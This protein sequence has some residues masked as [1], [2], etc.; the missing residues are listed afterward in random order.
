MSQDNLPPAFEVRLKEIL[1]QQP[2][3]IFKPRLCQ[4]F[5]INT[6]KISIEEAHALLSNRNIDFQ[7]VDFCP[8]VVIVEKSAAQE[9][10][11][12]DIAS[13]GLLYAQGLESVLPVIILDPRPHQRVLDLCAAP[14]S[15]TSQMAMHMEN[16]GV[17]KANEPIRQRR[18]PVGLKAVLQ[19]MGAQARIS[20][21][22]R[23]ASSSN[24]ECPA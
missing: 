20:F 19:L 13:N 23:S 12:S 10:L 9:I 6:L 2:E 18:F 24:G 8:Y 17:L 7:K 3:A 21:D 14:G 15:K 4:C 5:R 16:K 1:P 22:R 11:T